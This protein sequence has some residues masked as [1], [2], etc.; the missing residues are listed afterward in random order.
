[1]Y[2]IHV[3]RLFAGISSPSDPMPV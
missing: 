3:N 2:E 1:V